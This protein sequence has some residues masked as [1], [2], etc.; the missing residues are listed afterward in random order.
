M[1]TGE[2]LVVLLYF[3]F[4]RK[5]QLKE[6]ERNGKKMINPLLCAIPVSFDIVASTINLISLTM[7]AGSVYSMMRGF[8]VPVTFVYSMVFLKK[9]FFRHNFLAIGL[10]MTG[11]VMVFIASVTGTSKGQPTSPIGVVMLLISMCIQG[12][13]FITEEILFK[14]YELHPFQTVGFEGLFGALIYVPILFI[15]QT[16]NCSSKKLCPD[17]KIDNLS[18]VGN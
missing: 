9:K 8:I 1:F 14:Q 11:L 4:I 12:G 15:S 17:G 13:M 7:V 16:I 10:I 5:N 2:A 18:I 6:A 3:F